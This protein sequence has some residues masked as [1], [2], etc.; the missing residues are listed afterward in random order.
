MSTL[1]KTKENFPTLRKNL[2]GDIYFG[3]TPDWVN[4]LKMSE[5]CSKNLPDS[6]FVASRKAPMSFIYA[7]G[8]EFFPVYTVNKTDPDSIYEYFKANKV[9]HAIVASLRRNPEKANGEV[10]NTIHRLLQPI[11][12]KYPDRVKVIHQIGNIEP[13]YLYEIK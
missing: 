13:A 6:A 11:E 12:E 3:Y 5:W 2:A 1:K 7:G 4:F 9:T 10:I 8:K